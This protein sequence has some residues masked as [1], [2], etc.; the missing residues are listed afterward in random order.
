[1]SVGVP[2]TLRAWQKALQRVRHLAAAQGAAAGHR[3]RAARLHR[4]PDLLRP[5]RRGQGDLRRLP[6]HRGAVPRP[7]RH[8]ARRR[9]GHHATPTSRAPTSCIAAQ[10]PRRASTRGPLAQAIVDTVQ[11]PPLR[12]GSTRT[13]RPGVMELERPRGLQGDRPRPDAHR[14]PRARRLRHGAAVAAAA[15]PSARRSTSSRAIRPRRRCRASSALHHYLEA[16][17]AGLRRPRRLPRRP[18]YVTSR[19]RGCSSDQFA[20]AARAR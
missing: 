1:M 4:R 19:S 14:L 18:G 5:D 9:H 11:H 6:G 13:V 2:G 15:R 20:A 16:S 17:R 12:P 8:A 3:R 7:R 10:G